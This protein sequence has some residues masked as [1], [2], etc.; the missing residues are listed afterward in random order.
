MTQAITRS[1]DHRMTQFGVTQSENQHGVAVAIETIA[2]G[3]GLAVGGEHVLAAAEGCD[4]HDERR[5]GQVEVRE[6]A[7]QYLEAET[8]VDEKASLTAAWTDPPAALL[9]CPLERAGGGGAD[10]DHAPP[11][12]ERAVDRVGR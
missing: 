5:F 7:A 1:P 10:G 12:V 11:V 2:P 8:G 6:Q 4:E 9:G 3:N